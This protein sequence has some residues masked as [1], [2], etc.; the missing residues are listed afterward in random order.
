MKFLI[1]ICLLLATSAGLCQD[2]IP[3]RD[4]LT[5]DPWLHSRKAGFFV[6]FDSRNSFFAGQGVKIF[7]VRMG[8]QHYFKYRVGLG[9][10]GFNNDVTLPDIPLNRPDATDTSDTRFRVSYLG[11]F[12]ERILLKSRRWEVSV[13]VALGLGSLNS[14]YEDTAGVFRPLLQTPYTALEPSAGFMFRPIRWIGV[15]AGVGYRWIFRGERELRKAFNTP[16]YAIRFTIMFGE[17]YRMV[18]KEK[19]LSRKEPVGGE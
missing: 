16:F 6:G 7:G 4:S 12:Y 15:G 13:P 18:F 9:I 11:L 3:A 10:Y 8:I 5:D 2:S 17:L 1:A 14:S 19:V